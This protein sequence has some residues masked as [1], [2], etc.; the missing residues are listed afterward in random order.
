MRTN[1]TTELSHVS[2]SECFLG[3]QPIYDADREIRAYELL[4]RRNATD[5]RAVFTDGDQATS[6]VLLVAF[7]EI[8]LPTVSPEQPVFV[9][10]TSNLLTTNPMA[11]PDRCVIEVLEDV[12]INAESI[13]SLKRLRSLGYRL[14]LDDF[15]YSDDL[16]P[17]LQLAQYVKLD[18]RALSADEL[19]D[20]V[21]LLKRYPVKIIAEKVETE[22]EF[23]SSK[24]LECDLFQGYYLRKPEVLR[25]RRIPA[26]HLSA[27]SLL[28]E[29][30]NPNQ[31]AASISAVLAR[32]AALLYGLLRLANSALYGRSLEIRSAV[33]AVSLLGTERVL[34]WASLLV[35]SGFDN[36]PIGYLGFALQRARA[37]EIL[38]TAYGQTPHLAYMAGL[39]STL[40]SILNAPLANIIEPLPLDPPLRGAILRHEA[41]LGQ[42][43]DAVLCYEAG[44]FQEASN[45]GLSL[46]Q[47]QN[48]FWQAASY[49][50]SMITDLKVVKASSIR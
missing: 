46:H 2:G 49:S 8:G 23:E 37:C 13:A 19:R 20:H 16:L 26:N 50:A 12:A 38:A 24:A 21:R 6:E 14:A 15:V 5:D 45:H 31:S 35:L 42:I 40:D 4:Y 47:V 44:G 43:L 32:D 33:Q 18:L 30:M 3:R 28:I 22:E 10:H 29:C 36:C 17:L 34:S 48:A 41:R 11:P 27:L 7:L 39:L 9:N 25:G 1:E